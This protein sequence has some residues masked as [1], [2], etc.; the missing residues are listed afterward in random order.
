MNY[1][2]IDFENGQPKS[3]D[4]LAH[5]HFKVFVFVGANQKLTVDFAKAL[6]PLGSHAE[7]IQI[8]GNGS[9][10]LDFHIAYYLG[11]LAA[12]DPK[13]CFYVVSNDSGFDPLIQHLKAKQIVA[14]RVK[15]DIP[16][17]RAAADRPRIEASNPKS[18]E[19]RLQTIVA[20]LQRLKAARPGTVKTL[21]NT[22]GAMFRKEQLT[23]EE[24]DAH[25]Q[26]LE[27]QNYLSRCGAKVSY[28]LPSDG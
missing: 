15:A 10:A 18:P 24:I 14:R 28:S 6:Q 13:A 5:D 1:V 21:R 23:A 11:R 9:N 25:I 2:L 8:S 26:E 7:Y 19:E 27:N 17:D 20:R 3:F 12:A 4:H 22:I 16:R